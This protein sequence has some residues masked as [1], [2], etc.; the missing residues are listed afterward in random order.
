MNASAQYSLVCD[1][2]VIAVGQLHD[3]VM[4]VGIFSCSL[5]VC[6]RRI[7]AA[8]GDVVSHAHAKQARLLQTSRIRDMSVTMF[9]HGKPQTLDTKHAV[10]L[11]TAEFLVGSRHMLASWNAIVCSDRGRSGAG[12]HANFCSITGSSSTWL[13]TPMLRLN[14]AASM[15]LRSTPSTRIDPSS[16]SYR[17][18]SSATRV[19]LPAGVADH[20]FRSQSMYASIA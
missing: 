10:D 15:S 2:G 14:H 19:V 8:I 1:H 4:C 9:G 18:A 13:T 20:H 16:G 11:L 3:E 6:L 7:S 5:N 12:S 17:R